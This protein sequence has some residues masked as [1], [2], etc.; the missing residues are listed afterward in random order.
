MCST[1]AVLE[2]GETLLRLYQTVRQIG[3]EMEAAEV[4]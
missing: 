4:D 1:C 3:L 2:I